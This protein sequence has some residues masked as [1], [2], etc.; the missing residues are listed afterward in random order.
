MAV[1]MLTL[2]G[3]G[4]SRNGG[5]APSSTAAATSRATEG[6]STAG[7]D[8]T[9]AKASACD[10]RSTAGRGT[11][12]C[13]SRTGHRS[14]RPRPGSPS[15]YIFGP[16]T[17]MRQR[18]AAEKASKSEVRGDP[19]GQLHAG[20]AG[21]PVRYPLGPDPHR[22]YDGR[23]LRVPRSRLGIRHG[24]AGLQHQRSHRR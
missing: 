3:C 16:G 14:S 20:P 8:S 7:G 11:G 12:I 10:P 9:A 19:F 17:A 15:T 21:A 2:A 5:A 13:G 6:G 18:I 24:V 23:K 22:E 1:G 4:S